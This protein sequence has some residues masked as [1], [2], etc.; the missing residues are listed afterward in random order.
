MYKLPGFSRDD[1]S[2][3]QSAA[4][5]S[6]LNHT[7]DYIL[8]RFNLDCQDRGRESYGPN[9]NLLDRR[10]SFCYRSRLFIAAKIKPLLLFT[11]YRLL[12]FVKIRPY[13]EWSVLC[14]PRR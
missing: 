13:S 4:S 8:N 12:L 1:A 9:R 10:F 5:I 2:T 6:A 11:P 3:P 14:E 7:V